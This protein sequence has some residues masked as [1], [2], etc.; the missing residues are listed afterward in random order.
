MDDK[1]KILLEKLSIDESHYNHFLNAVLT[2]IKLNQK[3][4]KCIIYIEN[5]T[6][7]DNEIIFET[8]PCDI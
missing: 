7:F 3:E 4:K 1:I 6:M 8:I 2:K 5:N